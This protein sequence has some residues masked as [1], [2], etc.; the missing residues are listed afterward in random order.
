MLLNVVLYPDGSLPPESQ[1][2]LEELAPWM[3]V[4]AEAIHGTRPWKVFGEG[5]TEAAAGAFQE[6]AAYTA[7]DTRQSWLS[8]CLRPSAICRIPRWS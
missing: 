8:R 6:G 1:L 4:N 2:L 7:R 5:P 3:A